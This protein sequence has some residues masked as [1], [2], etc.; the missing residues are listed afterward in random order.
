MGLEMGEQG[1]SIGV[2]SR[3]ALEVANV[4]LLSSL[5][6]K[7]PS[8]YMLSSMYD[9]KSFPVEPIT[10]DLALERPLPCV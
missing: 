5:Q 2:V 1:A 10:A 4:G 6:D 3:T 8:T 7:F 9:K